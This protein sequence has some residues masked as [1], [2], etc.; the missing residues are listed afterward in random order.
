MLDPSALG[1]HTIVMYSPSLG[2][3]PLIYYKRL[4]FGHQGTLAEWLTRC[5]AMQYLYIGLGIPFGG[6]SSNLTGVDFFGPLPSDL[7]FF[8]PLQGGLI[9]ASSRSSTCSRRDLVTDLF[10]LSQDLRARCEMSQDR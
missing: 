6:V 5:P 10:V 9:K 7:Q 8:I 3:V 2:L 1:I 4:N